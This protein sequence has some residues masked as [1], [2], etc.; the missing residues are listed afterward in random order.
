MYT[1]NLHGRHAH[2]SND[3]CEAAQ[4]LQVKCIGDS[5]INMRE[6]KKDKT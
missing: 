5:K 6:K 4:N 1:C 3:A 2:I